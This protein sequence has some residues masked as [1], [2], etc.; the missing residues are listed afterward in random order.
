MTTATRLQAAGVAAVVL[1]IAGAAILASGY[2]VR[3]TELSDG[4]VWAVQQ[5]GNRFAKVNTSTRELELVRSA[6]EINAVEQNAGQ[7]MIL[8]R[9]RT[10]VARIDQRMPVDL[11]EDTLYDNAPG[12]TVEVDVASDWVVYR[13]QDGDI[14][15]GSLQ[16]DA[17][18]AASILDPYAGQESETPGE[19]RRFQT[20]AFA[21]DPNGAVFMYSANEGRVVRFNLRDGNFDGDE[22]VAA[23]TLGAVPALTAVGGRWALLDGAGNLWRQGEAEPVPVSLNGETVLQR[24]SADGNRVLLADAG[25]LRSVSL[26]DGQV[27]TEY[28]PTTAGTPALPVRWRGEDYAAWIAADGSAASLWSSATGG[29]A[30]DVAGGIP[31]EGGAPE[32]IFQLAGGSAV[33]NDTVSGVLWSLPDGALIPSS[34]D[35]SLGQQNQDQD[36]EEQADRRRVTEPVAPVAVD[37]EFGVRPGAVAQLPVMLND[38][39]ANGD[40]LSIVADSDFG[41]DS[42]FGQARLVNQGQALAVTVRPGAKGTATLRYRLTD[43]TRTDGLYSDWATVRLRILSDTVNTAP[44]HCDEL[45]DD[46]LQPWPEPQVQPGGAIAV[47]VLSGWHD[48]EG[49]A[50]YLQSAEFR[51]VAPGTVIATAGGEVVYRHPNPSGGAATVTITVTVADARGAT[52]TKDLVVRVTPSPSL[53]VAP[54]TVQTVPG[55]R[56]AI[57]PGPYLDG[58]SGTWRLVAAKTDNEQAASVELDGE[59]HIVFTATNPGEHQ[60][61][62][63]V[64]DDTTER[65]GSIRVTVL[66]RSQAA[67]AV[68]PLTAFVHGKVDSTVDVMPA[69]HNPAGLPLVV[70][71]AQWRSGTGNEVEVVEQ[72][73]LRIRSG[74][75]QTGVIG[76]IRYELS[77]GSGSA[78]GR[79]QGE[80]VV[81]A[82]EA[83]GQLLP[84]AVDDV[85][86]ARAGELLDIPVLANDIAPAG[87][88]MVL[89]SDGLILGEGMGLAFVSGDRVRAIAPT[90]P[91]DYELQYKVNSLGFAD[92]T[93]SARVRLQVLPFGEN[94]APE[95]PTLSARVVAGGSVLI[96]MPTTGL[97]QDGDQV[98][99]DSIVEQPARGVASLTPDGRAIRYD[100]ILGDQGQIEFRYQVRDSRGRTA[101]AL[102]RV[103]VLDQLTNPSP[104]AF[105]D[106]AEVQR[107]TDRTV[108]VHPLRNDVD[109]NGS[110]LTLVD[111]EPDVDPKQMPEEYAALRELIA[112]T[113]NDSVMLR[114]G[115]DIAT[116]TFRYTVQNTLGDRSIGLI[117]LRVVREVVADA[118]QLTD[119]VVTVADRGNFSRAGID[120]LDGKVAWNSG[121][122]ATLQLSFWGTPPTDFRILGNRIVGPLPQNRTIIP[123]QVTGPD[124]AGNEAIG[125]GFLHIPGEQELLPVLAEPI[126][127]VSVLE[128]NET[129]VPLEQLIP[130]P[131]GDRIIVAEDGVRAAGQRAQAECLVDGNGTVRYVAGGGAP[132][133]DYCIVSLR[134]A[135]Q[136][137]GS[138]LAIPVE[139][140]PAEP[141]PELRSTA[142]LTHSPASPAISFNLVSMVSW[143]GTEDWD[144]LEIA[145]ADQ[146]YRLEHFTVTRSGDSLTLFAK[147]TATPGAE[148]VVQVS[149][150]SHPEVKPAAL[151]LKVGPAPTTTPRGGHVEQLCRQDDGN[152]CVARVIGVSAAELNIYRNTQLSLAEVLPGT[153]TGMTTTAEGRD[154]IRISWTDTTDGQRCEIPFTVTDH[155]GNRSMQGDEGVLSLDFRGYPKAAIAVVQS[156]F[157]AD[158]IRLR[159]TPAPTS[160]YPTVDGFKIMEGGQQVAMCTAEGICPDILTDG[161]GLPLVNGE[162][163]TYRAVAVSEG[164]EARNAVQVTAWPLALPT[165]DPSPDITAVYTPGQTTATHG[166]VRIGFD[167]HDPTTA[168]YDLRL[169]SGASPHT[170]PTGAALQTV[171]LPVGVYANAVL[172]PVSQYPRPTGITTQVQATAAVVIRAVGTPVNLQ[173]G[174]FSE[175]ADRLEVSGGTAGSNSSL[176]PLE[177][178]Y[179]ATSAA[180]VESPCVAAPDGTLSVSGEIAARTGDGAITLGDGLA[181]HTRYRLWTCATNGFGVISAELSNDAMVWAP[182]SAPDLSGS[183]YQIGRVG[184]EYHITGFTGPLPTAP[185]GFSLEYR[186]YDED[187]GIGT[188]WGQ[189]LDM[190]VR[191]CVTTSPNRCGAEAQFQPAD[192]DRRHQVRFLNPELR[193]T[194][195]GIDVTVEGNGGLGTRILAGSVVDYPIDEETEDTFTAAPGLVPWPVPWIE[196]AQLNVGF[197]GLD[198]WYQF[199]LN[200]PARISCSG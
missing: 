62:Y 145:V 103:L 121:D 65:V 167:S 104:I 100:S 98:Y 147:D 115:P 79:A 194:A 189:V 57:D 99:L 83:S 78:L 5:A 60:L 141:Q 142:A 154:S 45:G 3:Q 120:V 43:G 75:N 68:A 150:A 162:Q 81:V 117:V 173:V 193:C 111:I 82:V 14:Y 124:F 146:A 30:L 131:P 138:V 152:S 86:T 34:L 22:A 165:I 122:A 178:R 127:P 102:A 129:R 19:Q 184:N 149:L 196:Q 67:I 63:T 48:A 139:V 113:T 47:P 144:S 28:S 105:S 18:T 148:E 94:A 97:D 118:P 80:L 74:G 160:S 126:T 180:S 181:E 135:S 87:T 174:S 153:C 52:T 107:G 175:H 7:A 39:D 187:A 137:Q 9:D 49:D 4:G 27:R 13:T 46:C 37:D 186:G 128:F 170:V 188:T 108:L 134:Y 69:V 168:R 85:V 172:T 132:W 179:V 183:L 50:I 32:P 158:R 55:Q 12:G 106:Y 70:T 73:L 161:A 88:P 114:A 38:F 53:T 61:S 51:G 133:Q 31:T 1:G 77:D 15:L 157:E 26:E 140:Q 125:Y 41:L 10:L 96:P 42:A 177:V 95:P 182:P 56:L 159:V 29:T 92:L 44:Q 54:F 110:P 58:V 8:G 143:R 192:A 71:S 116:H 25:S 59:R 64:A 16:P 109:P 24:P 93:D 185:A 198:D 155:F 33:L 197:Q 21:L 163:R 200:E 166:T 76:V 91:G 66:P 199:D 11:N 119:T 164:G 112:A 169:T 36:Q 35:W 23:S 90:T 195:S 123:F 40:V 156:R 84:I 2:E 151:R 171:T 17:G 101:G 136:S 89:R 190:G 130:V 176:L 6:L 72:R 20:T 191:A